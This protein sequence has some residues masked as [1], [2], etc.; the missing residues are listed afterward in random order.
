MVNMFDMNN[1]MIRCFFSSAVKPTSKNPDYDLWKY[2]VFDNMYM[3]IT[4]DMTVNELVVA[5]DHSVSWRRLFW[6]RYKEHRKKQRSKI[7]IDWTSLFE[8]MDSFLLEIK[9]SIPFKVLKIKNAEAD[10]IIAIICKKRNNI[11]NII[12]TDE[13]YLQLSSNNV[14]IYNPL[15][16][17]YVKCKDPKMFVIEKCLTGQS[18]DGIFNVLTPIDYPNN[19]RKPPFGESKL[20]KVLNEGYEN[21]LFDNNL[22]ERFK[23]NRVLMDFDYIPDVI[24]K[25]ILLEYDN[26]RM[27]DPSYLY[28]FF[29]KNKFMKYLENFSNVENRLLDLYMMED[30]N[31]K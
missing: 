16:K 2:L 8:Q 17:K 13:D 9:E 10:D 26:Y 22:E 3:S 6:D 31:E 18:K 11:Y 19:K 30:S 5:V 21:W 14:K 4:K 15:K 20:K 24:S 7:D 23:F 28:D 29:Y 25:R 1:L 12:S 27:P